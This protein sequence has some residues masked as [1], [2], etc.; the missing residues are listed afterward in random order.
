MCGLGI[1]Q[2]QYV[3]IILWIGG[4][5]GHAT[6]DNIESDATRIW[7]PFIS[8]PEQNKMLFIL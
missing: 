6:D 1:T 7:K 5:S 2:G 4:Q 3:N 8:H